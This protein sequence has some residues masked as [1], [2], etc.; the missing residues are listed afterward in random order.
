MTA[1]QC[2]RFMSFVS[3]EPMSGCWLWVGGVTTKYGIFRL[4]KQR[5]AHRVS[6]EHFVGPIAAGLDIDH[7]CR[8]KTCVNPVH[9][10]AVSERENVRRWAATITHCPLGHE[11]TPE[12]TYLDEGR[13][14]CL[15]C[16]RGYQRHYSRERW[17]SGGEE[18][19]AKRRR[20]NQDS[21]RR[22]AQRAQTG[23]A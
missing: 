8:V 3:P 7:R 5:K 2:E 11:Y 4:G 22:C 20:W 14:R 13:R 10:E 23:M 6:Y 21:Y 12:N 19:R 9:L 1:A 16:R 17:R 18:Y 15:I